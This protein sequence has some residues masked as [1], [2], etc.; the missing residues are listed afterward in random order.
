MRL[1]PL[2]VALWGLALAGGAQ[3][4]SS[5]STLQIPF[6]QTIKDLHFPR[7][8]EWPVELPTLR[9]FRQGRDDEPRPHRNAENR[10]LHSG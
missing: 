7:L 4:E 3:G 1:L 6:G 8:P 5:S 10:N 2:S 9:R